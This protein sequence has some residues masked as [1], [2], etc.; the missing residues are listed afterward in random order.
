MQMLPQQ[1][2]EESLC[3][4]AGPNL[5]LC[6]SAKSGVLWTAAGSSM[7]Q[8]GKRT[9]G[10]QSSL[11]S[12]EETVESASEQVWSR[13]ELSPAQAAECGEQVMSSLMIVTPLQQI[14]LIY[15]YSSCV[16]RMLWR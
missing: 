7:V 10:T 2:S 11:E 3:P 4:Q 9:A 15:L 1:K 5:L 8:L 13:P 12:Q 6:P 16:L 14:M